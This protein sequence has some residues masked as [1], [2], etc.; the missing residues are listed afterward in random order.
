MVTRLGGHYAKEVLWVR[1]IG[2]TSC[3]KVS[4]D[5]PQTFLGCVIVYLR[6]DRQANVNYHD[7]LSSESSIYRSLNDRSGLPPLQVPLG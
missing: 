5:W 6:M 4:I 1:S 2:N 3:K 7:M